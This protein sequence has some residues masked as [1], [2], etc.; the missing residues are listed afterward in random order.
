M[1]CS[2]PG[3]SVHGISPT[4]ILEGVAISFFKGSS[5]TRDWTRISCLAG[6]FFTTEPSGKQKVT[7]VIQNSLTLSDRAKDRNIFIHFRDFYL[8]SV[9]WQILCQLFRET[10]TNR[11]VLSDGRHLLAKGRDGECREVW[12]RWRAPAERR[13]LSFHPLP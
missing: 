1:D 9:L 10:K 2:P 4:R 13:D 11:T 12:R 6:A 5:Q 8:G 3:S 7:L